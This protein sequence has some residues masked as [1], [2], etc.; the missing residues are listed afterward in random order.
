MRRI[1]LAAGVLCAVAVTGRTIAQNSAT[2]FSTPGQVVG[3]YSG[4]VNPVGN[5]LPQVAPPVGQA[6]TGNA[7][8]RPYDPNHPYDAFKGS[9]FS[10]NDLV[11]PLV[12]PD[13]QPVQPPDALDRL[14]EK[15][16]AF[17]VK[18]P[19]PPARPP[20]TPGISRRNKER[21]EMR[22]IPWRRD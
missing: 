22:E 3:S 16:K 7:Q 20:Y 10:P 13:G 12:G 1:V 8:Q 4:N 2:G 9:S 11:A 14:S 17:F 6:I 5:R 21:R 19:A 18:T 15:I